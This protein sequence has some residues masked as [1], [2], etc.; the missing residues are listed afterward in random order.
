MQ[1]YQQISLFMRADGAQLEH[2]Y[3]E[4]VNTWKTSDAW[5]HK[6]GYRHIKVF[7]VSCNL[8]G[9]CDVYREDSME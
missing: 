7:A 4:K 9:A 5:H 6:C 8:L 1:Q 3:G 2:K